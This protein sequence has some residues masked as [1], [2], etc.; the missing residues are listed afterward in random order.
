VQYRPFDY[1]YTFYRDEVIG[2]IIPRGDS[3]K[4]LMRHVGGSPEGDNISL[5]LPRQAITA[6]FGFFVTRTICDINCTGKAGQYG[7]GL[8]FPLYLYQETD[9]GQLGEQALARVPNL[10][11][12]LVQRIGES[13]GAQF[14]DEKSKEAGTF[15]P[16]DVLNY[17]YAVLHSPTY[18][19]RYQELLKIDFPRVPYPKDP[20]TFWRLVGLGDAIRRVH[21]LE[22]QAVEGIATTFPVDG[23]NEITRGFSKTSVGWES[24]EEAAGIGR[25]W[26]NDQQ[27]FDRVPRVAWEQPIGGYL[28]AQ[29][30]LKDRRNRKL[31]EED[32]RHYQKIVVA[33]SETARLMREVDKI[34]LEGVSAGDNLGLSKAG[35]CSRR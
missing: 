28:P 33:L 18:R 27:Y 19:E 17:I 25:V 2:K 5:L 35:R 20:D 16:I 14:R 13:I 26:I 15:S 7:S 30:W 32:L 3:R 22:L 9:T 23:D 12:A 21:L 10:D 8:V 29:K 24:T 6:E 1:R 4:K 34:E 31:N 11:R